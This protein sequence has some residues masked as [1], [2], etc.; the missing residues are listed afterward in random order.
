MAVVRASSLQ[1]F[2]FK[3]RH[4]PRRCN[5]ADNYYESESKVKVKAVYS[6]IC[7]WIII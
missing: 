1:V 2:R 3:T 6:K 7:Y 4:Q 5:I